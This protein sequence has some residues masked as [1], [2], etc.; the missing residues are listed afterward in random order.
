VLYKNENSSIDNLIKYANALRSQYD[1]DI[2]RISGI[3]VHPEGVFT[4]RASLMLEPWT[5]EPNK[6]ARRG[7]S[8]KRTDEVVMAANKAGF[9]VSVH[10]D[11]SKTVR[12]TIDSYLKAKKAGYSDARNTLQ[13]FC[14]C[15]PRR[16][17]T[18]HRIQDPGQY[19]PD[20]GNHLGWRP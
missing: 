8:A 3:K 2:M 14:Q 7:V 18:R 4:S 6:I 9:D 15:S 12:D 17:A 11:G 13:P 20:M 5:D 10:V 16:H 1:S 19:N